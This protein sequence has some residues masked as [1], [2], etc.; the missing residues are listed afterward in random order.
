VNR[1]E[2]EADFWTSVDDLRGDDAADRGAGGMGEVE[3]GSGVY[4]TYIEIAVPALFANTGHRAELARSAVEALVKAAATTTPGGHRTTFGNPVRAS[5]VRAELGEPSGNLFMA[6]FEKPAKDTAGSISALREAA[7]G[8]GR[9]YG[10]ARE[11]VEMSVPDN[12]STLAD[13]VSAVGRYA[14]KVIAPLQR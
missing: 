1:V 10:L 7:D 12:H 5:Y 9:A 13:V 8:V 6:A 4:Y 3:Y 2:I 11:T 14:D